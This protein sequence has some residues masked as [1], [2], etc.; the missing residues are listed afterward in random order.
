MA[1]THP[2]TP[3][4]FAERSGRVNERFVFGA[5]RTGDPAYERETRELIQ[6]SRARKKPVAFHEVL[7]VIKH[8]QPFKPDSHESVDPAAP[9]KP[10]PSDLRRFVA[11]T[12]GLKGEEQKRALFWT[13]VGSLLDTGFGAD[14]AIEITDKKGESL[15]V[16]PLDV[17]LRPPEL[18]GKEGH[19]FQNLRVVIY[20]EIPDPH[21][22]KEEY[23]RKVREVGE[24]VVAKLHA[25]KVRV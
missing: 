18:A 17:T 12:L 2:H 9:I 24:E 11:D 20:G 13:A 25:A 15:C 4:Y 6:H 22:K 1:I 14:A 5:V 19:R 21:E 10:F 8:F 16:V 3:E 7:A 23:G